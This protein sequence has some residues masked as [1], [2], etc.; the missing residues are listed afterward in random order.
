[1]G[2]QEKIN[3]EIRHNLRYLLF[4][5]FMISFIFQLLFSIGKIFSNKDLF[6][7]YR[8]YTKQKVYLKEIRTFSFVGNSFTVNG[9]TQNH[10]RV[11]F[12]PNPNGTSDFFQNYFGKELSNFE[13]WVDVYKRNE[14][15]KIYFY[16]K[17]LD[18]LNF[19]TLWNRRIVDI[20]CTILLY[21]LLK[22][23]IYYDKKYLTKFGL[24][25]KLY[26]K[27]KKEGKLEEYL[28]EY[29]K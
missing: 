9:I 3:Y 15:A 7:F 6:F 28:K 8:T 12:F 26:N 17:D 19:R 21:T 29:I 25:F 5:V 4:F 20:L 27:L 16:Q 10:K 24:T 18:P 22:I 2:K 11:H 13:G 14:E 1:M 23:Q